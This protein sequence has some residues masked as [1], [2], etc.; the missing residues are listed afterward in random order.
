MPEMLPFYVGEGGT[1]VAIYLRPVRGEGLP[2]DVADELCLLLVLPLP[3]DAEET[4]V[5]EHLGALGALVAV[6][7]ASVLLQK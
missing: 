6:G 3:V 7:V 4:P 5:E 2:A 1:M